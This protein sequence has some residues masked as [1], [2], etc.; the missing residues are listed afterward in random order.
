MV[1]AQIREQSPRYALLTQPEV[2]RVADIQRELTDSDTILLEFTLGEE[3]S[4]LWAVTPTAVNSYELP[5]RKAIEEAAHEVYDLLTA[6]RYVG[7]ET[8]AEYASRVEAANTQ[9][10]P[11]ALALS[12]MLLGPVAGQLGTKRLL[13][14]SDGAL[15]H[16]PFEALPDPLAGNDAGQAASA[17]PPQTFEPLILRHEVVSLP[18]AMILMALRRTQEPQQEQPARK[19]IAVLADPVFTSDDPRT[20][21]IRIGGNAST[22]DTNDVSPARGTDDSSVLR[23]ERLP[24]TLREARTIQSLLPTDQVMVATGFD[25][26]RSHVFSDELRNYRI[27]HFA[28][29]GILNDE[30]PEQS[31]IVLSL[32]D[33]YGHKQDGFLRLHDIYKLRLPADLIVMSE[34]PPSSEKARGEGGVGLARGFMYAGSKSVITSLWAVDDEATSQ[35]MGYFYSGLLKDR[36]TPAAALQEAK[37]RMWAQGRWRAPYFWAAFVLQGEYNGNFAPPTAPSSR[38]LPVLVI[39]TGLI[40]L[41]IGGYT[42][43]RILRRSRPV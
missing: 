20:G 5:G 3:K 18:S 17:T 41:A 34:C 43:W 15:Q 32:V 11:R 25:A 14:V 36:L 10:W 16:I 13:I 42:L 22:K 38:L 39:V 30:R 35:L 27:I 21:F 33:E 31:G 40:I 28:T 19:T 29:Y 37:K 1:Q 8:S 9:Y 24:S 6:R 26:S 4:F 23:F 7:G 12:K 2:L